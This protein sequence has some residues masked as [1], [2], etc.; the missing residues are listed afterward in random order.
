MSM[1]VEG[2]ELLHAVAVCAPYAVMAGYKFK[3]KLTPGS[4]KKGKAAKQAVALFTSSATSRERELIQ[5]CSRA[6]FWGF[7]HVAH[8]LPVYAYP[9][10]F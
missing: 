5:V 2:D 9:Y 4:Q 3:V 7:S 6:Q 8:S 10:E 1:P